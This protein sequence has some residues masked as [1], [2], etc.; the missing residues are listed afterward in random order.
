MATP[1][2]R[3]RASAGHYGSIAAAKLRLVSRRHGSLPEM[4]SALGLRSKSG[5]RCCCAELI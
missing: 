5:E 1:G 2:L 4:P 3:M